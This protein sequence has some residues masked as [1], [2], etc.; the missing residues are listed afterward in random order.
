MRQIRRFAGTLLALVLL[1]QLALP[2]AAEAVNLK[3]PERRENIPFFVENLFPGDAETRVFTVQVQHKKPITLYYQAQVRPDGEKLAE[4]LRMR[5]ELPEKSLT[6]YD[7]LMKEAPLELEAALTTETE[8]S[9]AITV[10]LDTSVG[11]A[12]QFQSLTADFCWWYAEEEPDATTP[13]KP[14]D[15]KTG[16]DSGLWLH[17]ALMTVSGLLLFLMLKK[18]KKEERQ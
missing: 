4:V 10:Y 3:T 2:A 11:N 12:Y 17:G 14:E 5:I 16:D 18:R 15:P 7:G 8:V 13:Q 1:F 6:L 9:Y